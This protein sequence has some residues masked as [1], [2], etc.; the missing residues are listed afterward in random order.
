MVFID[1]RT[2]LIR[3][4]LGGRNDNSLFVKLELLQP[5]GSHKARTAKGILDAYEKEGR[6]TRGSDQIIVDSSG[7]NFARALALEALSRGYRAYA[8]IEKSYSLE[9]KKTFQALG[10]TLIPQREKCSA[11]ESI[12]EWIGENQDLHPIY[13]NQFQNNANLMAHRD[14]TGAEIAEQIKDVGNRRAQAVMLVAGMG[15]GASLIGVGLALNNAFGL[16][17]VRVVAV[18]P[19]ECD[20]QKGCFRPHDIQ[21][22]G[23]TRSH[24]Q[25]VHTQIIH[26]YVSVSLDDALEGHRW[27]FE[28]G[29]IFAGISSGAN[30]AA[31]LRL[32]R[33]QEN[34]QNCDFVTIA[35]DS[36]IDYLDKIPISRIVI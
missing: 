31:C 21:G 6:L 11:F 25:S 30:I 15:S 12:Q 14:G 5:Y 7:G 23:L 27:L 2:P 24:F 13:L 4:P 18:Q 29:K 16:E 28:K 8:C 22:I 32:L 19:E 35:Y 26:E 1:I 20:Y 34:P 10:G 17:N 33:Q 3:I 9:K 36:G